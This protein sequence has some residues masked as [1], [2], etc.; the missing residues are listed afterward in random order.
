MKTYYVYIVTNR[1]NGILYVGVTNDAERR[2]SEHKKGLVEGFSKKHGLEKLVYV[3]DFGDINEAI[4]YEKRIKR[5]RRQWKIN[6]IEKDNPDWEDL[7]ERWSQNTPDV[8]PD[9]AQHEVMRCWSGAY[10]SVVYCSGANC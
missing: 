8:T 4:A 3:T 10:C 2:A 5:W 7:F 1:K 9:A 6:L